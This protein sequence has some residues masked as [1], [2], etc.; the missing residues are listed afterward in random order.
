M[1][2]RENLLFLS[3]G[4]IFKSAHTQTHWENRETA[5]SCDLRLYIV[6]DAA[7]KY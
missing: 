5:A 7:G 1:A 6:F 4:I 3:I 2:F